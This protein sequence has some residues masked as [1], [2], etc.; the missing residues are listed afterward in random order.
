MRIKWDRSSSLLKLWAERSG[1]AGSLSNLTSFTYSS[2]LLNLPLSLRTCFRPLHLIFL[3]LQWIRSSSQPQ[4]PNCQPPLEVIRHL[5]WWPQL[6]SL[7]KLR[8]PIRPID[9]SRNWEWFDVHLRRILIGDS[10]GMG[11][12]GSSWKLFMFQQPLFCD[13]LSS[14]DLEIALRKRSLNERRRSNWIELKNW[15]V[16][17]RSWRLMCSLLLQTIASNSPPS[18]FFCRKV[19][20]RCFWFRGQL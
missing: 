16:T 5:S 20:F 9:Q 3:F 17:S 2:Q 10:N 1:L 6:P 4:R 13:V 11:E 12:E 7:A 14:A 15:L 19:R 18:I 8:E